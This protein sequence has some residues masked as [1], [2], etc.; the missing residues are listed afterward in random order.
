MVFWSQLFH[1]SDEV[2][3][4]MFELEQLII[5]GLV[6]VFGGFRTF[7]G[8][9][10][11]GCFLF[12]QFHK[13]FLGLLWS[14]EDFLYEVKLVFGLEKSLNE[15][16]DQFLYFLGRFVFAYFN[17]VN[18]ITKLLPEVNAPKLMDGLGQ[19]LNVLDPVDEGQGLRN[20]LIRETLFKL[21]K[22]R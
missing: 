1:Q 9:E 4:L 6:M 3:I 11:Y 10:L 22:R 19:R 14:F 15:E 18:F 21:F 16:P 7:G 12:D 17:S 20:Y 13:E 2:F 8:C 5:Q